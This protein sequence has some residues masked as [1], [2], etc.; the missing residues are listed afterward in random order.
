M[1]E[2]DVTY[3]F[4]RD[5]Y[6][7]RSLGRDDLESALPHARAA[8]RSLVW[9]NDPSRDADAYRRAVCAACEVD[10][11]YG[12]TGGA[13]SLSSVTAGTVSMAFGSGGGSYAE[14]VARAVR[15]ELAGTGLLYAGMGR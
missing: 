7:G 13:G 14:D 11:A 3:G 9:P 12:F 4:Y 15:G 1:S 6:G 2:P 8:V 10:A 5:E